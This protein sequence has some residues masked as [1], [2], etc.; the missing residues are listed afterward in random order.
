[1]RSRLLL[2]VSSAKLWPARGWWS[3]GPLDCRLLAFLSRTAHTWQRAVLTV[4]DGQDLVLILRS[5]MPGAGSIL[6]WLTIQVLD[7]DC[8]YFGVPK[9]CRHWP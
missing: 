5:L 7:C 1:M 8:K 6:S 9:V 4:E 2:R 3:S